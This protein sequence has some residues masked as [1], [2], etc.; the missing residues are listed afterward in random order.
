VGDLAD[1][2]TVR[3]VDPDLRADVARRVE[4]QRDHVTP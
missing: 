1:A 4:R 2:D 3:V